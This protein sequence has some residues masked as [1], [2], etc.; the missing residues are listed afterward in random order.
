[1]SG[2]DVQQKAGRVAELMEAR[3]RVR[4]ADLGQKLRRGARLMPR[5]V[6]RAAA[7]L[8]R[9]A[10]EAQVPRLRMRLDQA[11]IAAAYDTCVGYLKPLGAGARRRAVL[12]QI[13]TGLA[14]AVFVACL[15]VLA[16]LVWRGLL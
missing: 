12:M 14:G 1:M 2:L 11:E 8:A 7:Y 16:L 4:G 3:L 13:L 5:R 15:L 6:R 9:A 10:E